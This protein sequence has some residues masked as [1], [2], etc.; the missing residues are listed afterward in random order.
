M[1]LPTWS[2][3]AA[4]DVPVAPRPSLLTAT[5]YAFLPRGGQLSRL[6]IWRRAPGRGEQPES[7]K[8]STLTAVVVLRRNGLEWYRITVAAARC[9]DRDERART[10]TGLDPAPQRGLNVCIG[11]RDRDEDVVVFSWCQHESHSPWPRAILDVLAA[12]SQHP[13]MPLGFEPGLLEYDLREFQRL[14][15]SAR[16]TGASSA[17]RPAAVPDARTPSGGDMAL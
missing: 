13:A 6:I 15:S 16:A 9:G 4:Q 12:P 2:Q 7:L 17:L 11:M 5:R 3:A 14:V 1:P 10:R 8:L